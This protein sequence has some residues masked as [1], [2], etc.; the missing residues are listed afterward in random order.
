MIKSSQILASR[1]PQTSLETNYKYRYISTRFNK[2]G[3]TNTVEDS[4]L[5]W[6]PEIKSICEFYLQ[7]YFE[8]VSTILTYPDKSFKKVFYIIVIV[9]KIHN[10][11]N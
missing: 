1:K 3:L 6:N 11:W 9:T 2:Y 7:T 10:T 4:L 8:L 5:Q